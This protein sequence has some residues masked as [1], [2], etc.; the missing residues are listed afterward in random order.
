MS[1][2]EHLAFAFNYP[3][4]TAFCLLLFPLPPFR[5]SIATLFN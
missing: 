3:V 4:P 5:V 1:G 2:G